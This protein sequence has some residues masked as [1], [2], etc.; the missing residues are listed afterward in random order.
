MALGW[1]VNVT[2]AIIL[3]LQQRIRHIVMLIF[4]YDDCLAIYK[5]KQISHLVEVFVSLAERWI[6]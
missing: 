3:P 2:K 1:S 6:N 4:Q 5:V